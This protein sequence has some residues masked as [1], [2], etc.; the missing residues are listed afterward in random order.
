MEISDQN[1]SSI[2]ECEQIA[3]DNITQSTWNDLVRFV[4]LQ[5]SKS[6]NHVALSNMTNEAP[7]GLL[8]NIASKARWT[9]DVG[10]IALLRA[11]GQI[12]G[13]S[14]VEFSELHCQLSVGGAR[15]WLDDQHRSKQLMSRYLL[16]ANLR[17]SQNRQLSG[18]LLTFNH[19]N[20][21]I[22]NGINRAANGK[23]VGI[24]SV[25]SNWWD[26]CKP[27][28]NPITV[29][30]TKQWCVIKPLANHG[31]DNIIQ[32]ILNSQ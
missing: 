25:W 27:L 19:Y 8:H 4:E 11:N 3:S 12:I 16:D 2:Y 22:Y 14:C 15:C 21:W 24:G 26:D 31:L 10:E 28:P 13:I 18:M 7:A 20:K 32:E 9:S 1:F 30:Y 5:T 6:P 29:R 23:A 17:W